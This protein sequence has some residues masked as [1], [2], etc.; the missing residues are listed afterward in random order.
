MNDIWFATTLARLHWQ[1]LIRE[2][3]AQR[4]ADVALGRERDS[5]E[6]H[7]PALRR[8]ARVLLAARQPAHG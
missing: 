7:V 4:L 6:S 8:L 3:E 2:A 5:R 1:D